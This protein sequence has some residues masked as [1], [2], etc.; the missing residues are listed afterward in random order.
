MSSRS[1]LLYAALVVFALAVGVLVGSG[2][3]RSLVSGATASDAEALKEAQARAEAAQEQVE[4]GTQFADAVGPAA[5]RGWLANRSV[6]VVRLATVTDQQS[7]T[8][9]ATLGHAGAETGAT[10]T[11]TEDWISEERSAFRDALAK[12]ITE[13][14]VE[15]PEGATSSEVLAAALAQALVPSTDFVTPDDE[16]RAQTLWA[17]LVDGGLVKGTREGPSDTVILV[18]DSG[19]VSEL[20]AAFRSQSSGTVVAFTS[21]DVGDAGGVSTVTRGASAYGTWAVTAAL[22]ATLNGITG[23]Y[24]AADAPRLIADLLQ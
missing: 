15:P 23:S 14:I 11:L 10:L 17:L 1:R 18:A 5:V 12:Q 21:A 3:I 7:A 9:A 16:E 13:S 4:L 24:D 6:A 20:A 19:D 8:A 22:I 2:P